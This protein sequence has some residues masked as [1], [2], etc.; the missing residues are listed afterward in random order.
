MIEDKD[1]LPELV[2]S[3]VLPSD[4]QYALHLAILRLSRLT[5]AVKIN[6][7]T[8]DFRHHKLKPTGAWEVVGVNIDIAS[9]GVWLGYAHPDGLAVRPHYV[10]ARY[11]RGQGVWLAEGD[12]A[13]L[14]DIKVQDLPDTVLD[15]GIRKRAS[16][17]LKV[18]RKDASTEALAVRVTL[19]SP[20][21]IDQGLAAEM[22]PSSIDIL[23]QR[24][25][26][27]K[28]RLES[29]SG[30]DQGLSLARVSEAERC[31]MILTRSQRSIR[32]SM[33]RNIKAADLDQPVIAS[34]NAA[35]AFGYALGLAESEAG[36]RK[37]ARAKTKRDSKGGKGRGLQVQETAKTWKAMALPVAQKLDRQH[38]KWTRTKLAFEIL[39]HF[40][41]DHPGTATIEKWL[42]DEAEQPNGSLSS[43]ARS[44]KS[45][46]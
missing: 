2:I 40:D 13:T 30:D 20:N 31:G 38:P 6:G 19:A 7:V 5:G 10:G 37:I 34:Q 42:K 46:R 12:H 15:P 36:P 3:P 43:R 11:E 14:D 27:L 25:A 22:L 28:R 9:S 29:S 39:H 35:A 17:N 24:L 41:W 26:D 4:E 1:S 33:D 44:S 18:I 32:I 16:A 45:A 8:V 23:R 21:L